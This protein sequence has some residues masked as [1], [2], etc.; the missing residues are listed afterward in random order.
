MEICVQVVNSQ[1]REKRE[2][3][4][5]VCTKTSCGLEWCLFSCNMC[6]SLKFILLCLSIWRTLNRETLRSE[7]LSQLLP[8]DEV[9]VLSALALSDGA[10]SCMSKIRC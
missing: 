5:G 8:L 6:T 2:S 7:I 3:F 10:I 1:S 9:D 4:V